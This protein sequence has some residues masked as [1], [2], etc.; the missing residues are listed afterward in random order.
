[1]VDH[2][3]ILEDGTINVEFARSHPFSAE[4]RKAFFIP[5]AGVIL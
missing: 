4:K 1:M 2:L 5:T 3:T